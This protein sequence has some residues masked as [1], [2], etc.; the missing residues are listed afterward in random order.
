MELKISFL[1]DFPFQFTEKRFRELFSQKG[2]ITDVQL[3]YT[4]DGKF[5]KFGF[6]GYQSEQEAAKAAE[7][8]NSTCIDTS[9]IT[10][11]T[12]AALGAETKPQA[13]SKYAKDSSNYKKLHGIDEESEK[14]SKQKESE[15]E[16]KKNKKERLDDIFGEHKNDP[17]FIEFMK[18]HDKGNDI[19]DNDLGL[20][21]QTEDDIIPKKRDDVATESKEQPDKEKP[22]ASNPFGYKKSKKD[23]DEDDQEEADENDESE[24]EEDSENA[25]SEKEEDGVKLA[26]QSI[27]DL[28]YLKSLKN[29]ATVKK[30]VKSGEMKVTDLFTIKIRDIP[31]KT[32]RKDI[33]KFFKPVKAFSIRLPTRKHGFCYVGFKTEKEFK[34][35]MLK[36]RSFLSGKQ[37]TL[38]D[39]TEKNKE[40]ALHKEN[41]DAAK[42]EKSVKNSKWAKQEDALKNEEDICESG[43]IFFRNLSYTVNE[44]Q[45]QE[46]FEKYGPVTEISLPIDPVTRKIKGF[47][48]VT[49]VMPE[50][51]VQAFSELDGSTF[52]GRLLHLIPGKSR[53]DD[54]K[55]I[56]TDGMSFKQKKEMEQKKTAGSSHNWNTLFMGADAVANTLVKSYKTSKE[57]I[58][59]T[60]GSGSNAAVRL[61]LGETE[62]IIEMR[63]FLEAND[64]V[65]DAFDQTPKKRS[66]TVI[67]AKNLPAET[68]I[69]EIQPLF[70]KFGLLGRIV[71]PP[72]GVTAIIEFLEPSEAKKAFSKL[73][74]TK[75]KNLPLYLEWAPENTFKTVATK[76]MEI[77][78][79]K[80]EETNATESKSSKPNPFAKGGAGK[81]QMKSKT[82][83]NGIK[84]SEDIFESY[85]INDP[86]P[87]QPENGVESEEDDTEPEPGTTLFLRNLK[88]ATEVESVRNHFKH[89]GKIHHI[90]IATKKDPENPRNKIPLGYGFIQFKLKKSAEKA[91]KD[92]Q[93]TNIDGN[94]VEL[95]RSDRTLQ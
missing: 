61:A 41:P 68:H 70:A 15:K 8:F 2:H 13:W 19:W 30:E 32:K 48:T 45:L 27:S 71:L 10:V 5:R 49:F 76:P 33:I 21:E 20:M 29:K 81:E 80:V 17:K 25:E 86:L 16:K 56:N 88:F 40:A 78:T 34:K 54:E 52:Q 60:A 93:I 1:F 46:L 62:L 43:R 51:A 90:Q 94:S 22:S 38:I 83:E 35:A 50:H 87:S 37:V 82:N 26:D 72:S 65:L 92:M 39:F 89:I 73:A 36:N 9:R 14:Q 47:G 44:E 91:L 7:F 57:Q 59:D 31:F 69:S 63:K 75:F 79:V 53:D 55:N 4:K 95:K 66:K 3:K 85:V 64:V 77:D 24:N 74:Y 67:L 23:D 28:E 18:I 42:Q 12:C 58:M 11:E 84:K 6:V